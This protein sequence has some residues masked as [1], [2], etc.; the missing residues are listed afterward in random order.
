MCAGGVRKTNQ[1]IA[2]KESYWEKEKGE[3]KV[4]MCLD[5]YVLS[6]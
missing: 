1:E 5:L 4:M 2:E 6:V 3:A